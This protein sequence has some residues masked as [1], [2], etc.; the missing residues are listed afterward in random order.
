MI[1]VFLALIVCPVGWACFKVAKAADAVTNEVSKMENL[2]KMT[3][4]VCE[5]TT[6]ATQEVLDAQAENTALLDKAVDKLKEHYEQPNTKGK[7][8]A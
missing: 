2:R 4:S 7:Y 5:E 8:D 3:E 6:K 1:H